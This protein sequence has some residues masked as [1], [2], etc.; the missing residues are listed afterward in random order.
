MSQRDSF[1]CVWAQS[2]DAAIRAVG[3]PRPV[4]HLHGMPSMRLNPWKGIG[5]T[6]DRL[7]LM[8]VGN[9]KSDIWTMQVD[10]R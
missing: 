6:S 4:L 10:E 2:F 7:Y 9:F 5:I 8:L 3:E 1:P